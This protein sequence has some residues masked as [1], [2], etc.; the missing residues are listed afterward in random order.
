[1]SLE[2]SLF[3]VDLFHHVMDSYHISLLENFNL[4]FHLPPWL[5]KYMLLQLVAA[6]LILIIYLP[7]AKAAKT[8]QAPKG[9]FWN[10]FEVLLTFVREKIAKP[11]IGEKEADAYVP[12]LWTLF[13]FILFCNLLGMIPG[14]GSP[15]SSLAVTAVLAAFAFITIHGSAIYK[16]GLKGYAKSYI[17]HV[18]HLPFGLTLPVTI[19]V[20]AIE[21]LGAII[22]GLVLAIRLFGNMFAGHL[23]LASILG[24]IA[25]SKYA[26][27]FLFGPI[28]V[29][30]VLMVIAVSLLEIFIAFLQAYVFTF[31]TSLFLGMALHPHH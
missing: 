7:I 10:T 22:K 14:L 16:L 11:Q 27:W 29:G 28:T 30:S 31:L 8:G 3:A 15:N 20:S 19:L 2:S 1:M 24:F 4:G 25:M 18:G 21:I 12:F 13:L 17:P 5:S 9:F 23:V 26:G 6:G